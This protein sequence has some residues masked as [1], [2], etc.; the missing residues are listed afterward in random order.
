MTQPDPTPY[1]IPSDRSRLPQRRAAIVAVAL[2]AMASVATACSSDGSTAE[3]EASAP[4][5]VLTAVVEL[6]SAP[7]CDCCGGWEE[8]MTSHG[9][10]VE[11]AEEADLSAF[12]EARG[13]PRDAWSCHTAVIDGYT[14]EGHV[15]LEAIEDLLIERPD[16]DGIALP[17]MPPGSPGMSG[18]KQ[19]PFEVLAIDDGATSSF[20]QY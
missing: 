4:D 1:A 18:E 17:G 10:A 15:P 7:G 5:G 20:G 6:H 14:V 11:S 12:K 13:V 19:A 3:V 9:Y 2:L 8:Y 16:I